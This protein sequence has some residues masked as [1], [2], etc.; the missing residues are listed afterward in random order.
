MKNGQLYPRLFAL[1]T[2]C[3]VLA[4]IV[5]TLSHE[6]GHIAVA[7]KLGYQTKLYYASSGIYSPKELTLDN[8]YE[9]NKSFIMSKNKSSEKDE[10]YRQYNLLNTERNYI[11]LGG[12]IQTILVGTSGIVLLFLRRKRIALSGMKIADWLFIFLA[13]FWSRQICNFLM[14]CYGILN[15]R[16]SH[17]DDESRIDLY[18][19]LHIGTT[20]LITAT[21]ATALLV[22]AV[23]FVMP[24]HQRLTFISSGLAGSLLGWVVWM[25]WIG[26]VVLP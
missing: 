14:K 17:R 21:V 5:G 15:G 6:I 12:P 20:G 18:Y 8:Y 23:F 3:F 19:G 2:L 11:N 7:R 26:P 25:W 22:W 16:T 9:K 10:F 13:F 1:L 24:K 4:T